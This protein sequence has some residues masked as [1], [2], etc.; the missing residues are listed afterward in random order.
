[1][2]LSVCYEFA[3]GEELIEALP[4]ATLLINVSNDA[5]FGDS[6]GPHQNLEMARM[7]AVETGRYLARATNTGIT[8]IIGPTGV[9]QER[10]P[11]FETRV[12]SAEISPMQGATPYIRMGNIPVL[13][14]LA[15]VLMAVGIGAWRGTRK[16]R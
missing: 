11:Q 6:I 10:I 2:G 12:L 1:V 7:R 16:P 14:G 9:I 13:I 5:W 8:A 15:A 3:F 4:K